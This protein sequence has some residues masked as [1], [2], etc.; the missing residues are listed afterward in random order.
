MQRRTFLAAAAAPALFPQ[1]RKLSRRPNILILLADQHSPRVLG[2]YGDPVVRTPNLDALAARGVVMEQTY[3]QAPVCVP[4]R[5]SL[6]TGR[7]PSENRVWSNADLLPSDTPTFA[8]AL[9]AAG[10][11]TAL[12]GRMHFNGPDQLHGFQ[13]RLVGL[14]MPPYPDGTA[15]LPPDLLPGAT[16]SSKASVT[17]AGPGS[18]NY[19]VYDEDVTR[20]TIE[21]LRQSASSGQ[22]FCAVSGFVLPHSPYICPEREWNYYYGRVTL[23]EVPPGYFERLHPVVKVWRRNRGVEDISPEEARRARAG[24]YGLVS[25][26]DERAGRILRTLRE[27]GLDENTVVIYTSDHGEMAGENGMWWK[28]NFYESSVRV[29]MIISWP[30]RFQPARRIRRVA[31]LI[32]LAPTLCDLAGAPPMR[33]S[34]RSLLPLLE[35]K[36]DGRPDEAFSELAPMRDIPSTRMLRSGK[37]K[38]VHYDGMRP[39]LFDLD[40][41]PHEFVDLAE[42]PEQAAVRDRLTARVLEGWSA[43]TILTEMKRRAPDQQ[44]LRK[45]AVETHPHVDQLWKSPPGSNWYRK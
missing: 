2:C 43:E 20:A 42:R 37:W 27:T 18:T 33:T 17:I 22:P 19:T 24:Y 7:H 28:F 6:L 26:L 25:V 4:S 23:P 32:D 38:L 5:M 29:P 8:H 21:Y 11:R 14:I 31:S 12:I 39:Q 13:K 1:A 45:W 35:G 3:C 41:D 34:G 44:L 40:A 16:N 30:A 10:Y 36:P 15:P 9:G